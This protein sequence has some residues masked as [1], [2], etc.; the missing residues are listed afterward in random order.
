MPKKPNHISIHIRPPKKLTP[1]K[2][3]RFKAA[4]A[5]L[6]HPPKSTPPKLQSRVDYERRRRARKKLTL[7]TPLTR[8]T[9]AQLIKFIRNS[10]TNALKM[11]TGLKNMDKN[12]R[13]I[14]NATL[15]ASIN[16]LEQEI[17]ANNIQ[18]AMGR[19]NL[20]NRR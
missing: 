2:G 5:S 12:I 17:Q 14:N 6:P 10:K 15:V 20:R 16:R 19:M 13:N 1:I 11:A 18:N 9:N 7:A 3:P 4:H 8:G